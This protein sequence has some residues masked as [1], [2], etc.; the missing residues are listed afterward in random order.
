MI[1]FDIEYKGGNTVVISTKK[2]SLVLDPKL[3]VYGGKDI[4]V[5][6]GV[7]LATEDK[8]LTNDS[9]FKLSIGYPGSYE[10]SGFAI[11][12]FA[13][14]L[15]SDSEESFLKGV[16]YSISIS[17]IRVGVIGNINP[18]LSDDQLENLGVLDILI[19]PVGGVD[20]IDVTNAAK[21]ARR[22]DAKVII[23][24]H[25]EDSNLAYDNDQANL[26]LFVKEMGVEPEKTTKYKVKS[27]TTI[28]EKTTIVELVATK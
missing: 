25:Y 22:S 19:L 28:P 3:S 12:G 13:E 24:I 27:A 16:I 14:K 5:K 2:S 1:M 23:P 10:V 20:T 8:F 17:G 7:E 18:K 15:Y 21:I 11:N 26:A 6:D 9:S 4:V